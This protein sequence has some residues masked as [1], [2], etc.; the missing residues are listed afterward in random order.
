MS[1][2]I[3]Q[4]NWNLS[5]CNFL[6]TVTFLAHL[7]G[8]MVCRLR[9][10][11]GNLKT[12]VYTSAATDTSSYSDKKLSYRKETELQG[13]FWTKVE[14]WNW[15]MIFCGHY[16]SIFN[17][18]DIIDQRSSRIRW[19]KHKIRAIMPFKVIQEHRGRY[20]STPVCYFLVINTNWHPISCRFEVIANYCLHFGQCVLSQRMGLGATYTV[21][22]RLI[23][24]LT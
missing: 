17:H 16:R 10:S 6:K 13:V 1:S 12:R 24:K 8:N 21:R 4:V 20:Q 14:D 22:L 2:C 23:K 19:E 18:C 9:V 3:E 11:S 5:Y 15:E 7:W